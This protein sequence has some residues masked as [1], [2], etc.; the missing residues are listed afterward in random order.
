MA[1]E[2]PQ[3]AAPANSK[4]SAEPDI[5]DALSAYVKKSCPGVLGGDAKT[6]EAAL[7]TQE[8]QEILKL[9]A[10]DTQISCLI[11]QRCIH[12]PPFRPSVSKHTSL[13]WFVY[14]GAQQPCFHP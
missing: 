13:T 3:E 8:T 4:G 11:V 2:E 7:S 5:I 9:F 6:L 12:I 10:N 1:V 14:C